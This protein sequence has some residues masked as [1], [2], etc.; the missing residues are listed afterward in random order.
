M[1]Q[2]SSTTI[3]RSLYC[4]VRVD[5]V[6]FS[7]L[8][9]LLLLFPSPFP[10]PNHLP[11]PQ[12]SIASALL[13]RDVIFGNKTFY[14][15]SSFVDVRD[16][17]IGHVEALL[18][19]E[20]NGKRF[21]LVG[22]GEPADQRYLAKVAGEVFPN[23]EFSAPPKVPL[24]VVQN[25]LVPLSRLPFVGSKI[26]SDFEREIQVR[27]SHFHCLGVVRGGL[28]IAPLPVSAHCFVRDFC[29]KCIPLTFRFL[30]SPI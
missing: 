9:L 10:L 22:D 17:A 28:R 19:P 4:A 21:I 23:Y 12:H 14:F 30:L 13:L 25:V 6:Q 18:R 29:F 15:P 5:L 16:V 7:N 3:P 26:M 8:H 1:N 24:S 2:C 20:A 11:P 27:P